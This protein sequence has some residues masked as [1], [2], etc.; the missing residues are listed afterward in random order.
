[1][2]DNKTRDNTDFIYE[3]NVAK[4]PIER[5]VTYD[6]ISMA[7]EQF[8]KKKNMYKLRYIIECKFDN[9]FVDDEDEDDTTGMLH[10]KNME[11][12]YE[13]D[14]KVHYCCVCGKVDCKCEECYEQMDYEAWNS[15]IPDY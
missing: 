7:K 1:M 13:E 10:M 11:H 8:Q 4:K 5:R 3:K 15:E 6:N 2:I 12:D 9:R 14:N